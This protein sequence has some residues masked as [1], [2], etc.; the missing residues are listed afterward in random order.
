MVHL[1]LENTEVQHTFICHRDG[2]VE[3]L[4]LHIPGCVINLISD[5]TETTAVYFDSCKLKKEA[6]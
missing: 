5:A 4:L 2:A 3:V 6:F 1:G